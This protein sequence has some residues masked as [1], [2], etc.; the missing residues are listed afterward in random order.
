MTKILGIGNALLDREFILNDEQLQKT[1][2][3]KGNMTLAS[4]DEQQILIDCLA[5]QQIFP[6]KQSSGGSAANS[7]VAM[8]NLGSQTFYG[9]RVG[10]DEIGG[11][12]LADLNNHGVIT[13]TQSIAIGEKTGSCMVLITPDGERTM[14]T[15]LGTS[16]D[17]G[18]N[19]IDFTQLA[20]TDWL[21]IEGYL[22]MSPSAQTAIAELKQ[23]AKQ[24][25]IKIAVS[26]ADPAVVKFAKE[27]LDNVLAGGVDIIF[28]NREE[29]E[30]FT[31]ENGHQKATQALLKYTKL[32]VVTNG[33]EPTYIVCQDDTENVITIATPVINQVLD[34][35]GAGDNFAGTFLSAWTQGYDLEKS[36]QLASLVAS[37]VV[38]QLGARLSTEQYQTLKQQ[39]LV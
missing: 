15:H 14:Q 6:N 11:F 23:Q 27:G 7:I 12:Y 16:A 22:A 3:T 18:Q 28:C 4:Q 20:D 10:N 30:L 17:F 29:A 24:R 38:Q 32:A 35:N 33:A 8:S 13:A 2:L 25:N 26:F 9:C 37:Q 36:G 5:E 1:G 39:V 21:Y 34:T 31:G 19:D